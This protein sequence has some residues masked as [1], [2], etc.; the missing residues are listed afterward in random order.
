MI[1]KKNLILLNNDASTLKKIKF[2]YVCNNGRDNCNYIS[3][4]AH[5]TMCIIVYIVINDCLGERR[6][7]GNRFNVYGG[8]N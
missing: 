2:F 8:C 3:C 1:I 5:Q 7:K 6:I 4:N